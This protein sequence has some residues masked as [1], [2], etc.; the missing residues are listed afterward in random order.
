[1][2]QASTVAAAISRLETIHRRLGDGLRGSSHP[3]GITMGAL[4]ARPRTTPNL[5]AA[6]R[7]SD[8]LI[9][10]FKRAQMGRFSIETFGG[11][12]VPTFS[13]RGAGKAPLAAA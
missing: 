4:D 2:L 10:F 5:A 3:V 1:L 9:Y 7:E 12:A 8:R 13:T 11:S 6:I